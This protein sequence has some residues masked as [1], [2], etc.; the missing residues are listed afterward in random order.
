MLELLQVS[1]DIIHFAD[2]E[3]SYY[4]G[5]DAFREANPD[6]AMGAFRAFQVNY[7]VPTPIPRHV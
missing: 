7:H 3:L 5:Y 2:K 1:S 6:A 4:P